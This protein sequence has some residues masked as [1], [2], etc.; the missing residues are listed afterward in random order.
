MNLQN[1]LQTEDIKMQEAAEAQAKRAKQVKEMRFMFEAQ[2][3]KGKSTKI[4]TRYN[5]NTTP[6]NIQRL[7]RSAIANLCKI[8]FPFNPIL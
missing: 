8:D 2:V 4:S 1:Y 7:W 5:F 6:N 3:L